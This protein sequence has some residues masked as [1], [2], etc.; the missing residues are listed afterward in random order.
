[1]LKIQEK[2]YRIKNEWYILI[3]EK[4]FD[5]CKDCIFEIENKN[6]LCIEICRE[7]FI[8]KKIDLKK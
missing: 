7:E 3:P 2:A 5:S 8:Y 4:Q 6:G 1:M